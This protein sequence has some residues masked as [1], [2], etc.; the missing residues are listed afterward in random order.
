MLSFMWLCRFERVIRT[1]HNITFTPRYPEISFANR[2]LRNVQPNE[3]LTFQGVEYQ[4][5]API[6]EAMCRAF[7]LA[8]RAPIAEAFRG[9]YSIVQAWARGERQITGSE[10]WPGFFSDKARKYVPSPLVQAQVQALFGS[11]YNDNDNVAIRS[12]RVRC[13]C[14]CVC[15]C[16]CVWVGG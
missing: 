10:A 7:S 6:Q 15:V 2:L 11:F 8:P 3:T 9:H 14:L 16:V 13:V 5:P 4:A 1:I 12:V